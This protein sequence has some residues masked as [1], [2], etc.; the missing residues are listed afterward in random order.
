MRPGSVADAINEQR[1]LTARDRHLIR[2]LSDHQVLTTGQISRLAFDNDI[3]ARHRLTQLTTRGVLARFR[4]CQRP[5]SQAWR[6]TL[7]V[8][9]AILHAAATGDPLPR[10]SRVA[11]RIL[12]AA[13]SPRLDHLLETNE[14]FVCLTHHAR[15]HPGCELAQWWPERKATAACGAI[16]H[17]DGYGEW[18]E[19]GRAVGFFLELDRGTEALPR[20]LDKLSSY[21]QLVQAGITRPVLFLLPTTTREHHLHTQLATTA[22]GLTVATAAADHLAVTHTNPAGQ[23]WLAAGAGHR[24]RLIDLPSTHHQ[25]GP[26][27]G[28]GTDQ[29]AA[30]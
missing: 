11:D 25:H 10:P 18:V 16:A 5:G 9:G 13:E 19:H 1:R 12:S 21:R 26:R 7:G 15:T 29:G 20:L 22:G 23:V 24:A 4:R 17:P 3:T 27:G 2:L 8:L 30:A 6:Y 14:F 28:A